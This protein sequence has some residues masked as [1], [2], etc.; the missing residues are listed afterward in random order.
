MPIF[1]SVMASE[2]CPSIV[3]ENAWNCRENTS[4]TSSGWAPGGWCADRRRGKRHP[5]AVRRRLSA[6]AEALGGSLEV[7]RSGKVACSPAQ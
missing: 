5:R 3:N 2:A 1:S 7:R 6:A 4:A